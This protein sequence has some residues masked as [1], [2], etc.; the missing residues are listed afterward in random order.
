MDTMTTEQNPTV[1]KQTTKKDWQHVWL[2]FAAQMVYFGGLWLLGEKLDQ[3]AFARFLLASNM[4]V[5]LIAS[6]LIL[7]LTRR[8]PSVNTKKTTL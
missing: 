5:F 4:A 1:E 3:Y 7:L 2:W 6:L 8:K